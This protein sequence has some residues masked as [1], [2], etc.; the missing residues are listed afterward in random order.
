L[1]TLLLPLLLAAALP[2]CGGKEA[3][4]TPPLPSARIAALAGPLELKLVEGGFRRDKGGRLYPEA[5]LSF[6]YLGGAPKL[7]G[8]L[9]VELLESQSGRRLA[10]W[11]SF[12]NLH[13]LKPLERSYGRESLALWEKPEHAPAME[14]RLSLEKGGQVR[15]S[16]PVRELP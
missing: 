15:F 1:R 4:A 3:D 7:N 6:V 8:N 12:L 14:L 9:K 11:K 10:Q 5:K 2:G 13:P 16:L